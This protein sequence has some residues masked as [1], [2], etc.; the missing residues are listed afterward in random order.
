MIETAK[1]ALFAADHER[2]HHQEK[3]ES[4]NDE[5][6][7]LT[8]IPGAEFAGPA[9]QQ[10]E[11]EQIDNHKQDHGNGGKHCYRHRGRRWGTEQ[12]YPGSHSTRSGAVVPAADRLVVISPA[13]R[14]AAGQTEPN[15]AP[16]NR[17]ATSRHR[18]RKWS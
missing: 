9:P 16:P 15:P 4:A 2:C 11:Y 10:G 8:V 7:T 12:T 18:D 13:A 3:T 17:R 1:F 5:R 14:A 6:Q